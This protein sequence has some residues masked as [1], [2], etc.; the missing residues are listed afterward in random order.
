MTN[1]Y[2]KNLKKLSDINKTDLNLEVLLKFAEKIDDELIISYVDGYLNKEDN[3]KFKKIIELDKSLEKEIQS[4]S[5][6]NSF[7]NCG[8]I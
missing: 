6:K 5:L 7:F 2:Y 1:K 3:L 8:R 4:L